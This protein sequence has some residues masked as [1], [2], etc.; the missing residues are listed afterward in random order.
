M[1]VRQ[2]AFHFHSPDRDNFFALW[3]LSSTAT[4]MTIMIMIIES[5]LIWSED[6]TR[7]KIRKHLRSSI[8]SLPFL[9]KAKFTFPRNFERNI[10]FPDE[11]GRIAA[12]KTGQIRCVLRSVRHGRGNIS[13]ADITSHH[14]N[15]SSSIFINSII[16]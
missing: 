5:R 16:L 8:Q 13:I 14:T 3:S 6:V 15:S 9:R 10:K 1:D 4:T 12:V 7:I 11:S 2:K